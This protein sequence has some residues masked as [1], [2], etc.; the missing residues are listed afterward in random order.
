MQSAP[1]N[2]DDLVAELRQAQ[3]PPPQRRRAIRE[4]AGVSGREGARVVGV[5]AMTFLRWESGQIE[6]RRANAIRYREF[7]DALQ[8]LA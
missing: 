3:L 4:R 8:D 5:S 1:A 7:L 2:L 6:P